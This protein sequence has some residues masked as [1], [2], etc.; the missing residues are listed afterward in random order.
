MNISR[1]LRSCLR[2]FRLIEPASYCKVRHDWRHYTNRASGTEA[3]T[4][5]DRS[6]DIKSRKRRLVG[7]NIDGLNATEHKWL[8]TAYSISDEMDVENAVKLLVDRMGHKVHAL[9]DDVHEEGVM[10]R[11]ASDFDVSPQRPLHDIFLF[12]EGAIVFWGVPFDKQQDTLDTIRVA[13]KSSYSN[14]LTQ[15]E[16]ESLDYKIDTTIAKSK[17]SRNRVHLSSSRNESNFCMDQFA[18][19][20]AVALSV[21]LGVWESMLDKYIDSVGWVTDKMKEGNYEILSRDQIFRKIGELFD[22]KHNINLATDLTDLPDVYWDREEQE[23]MFSATINF[24][25]IRKR[26][27]VMNDKLNNCCELMNLLAAHTNDRH[28]VR[29]EYLI[30]TLIAIEV[31]FELGKLL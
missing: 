16:V 3:T 9:P 25:N 12:K 7:R 27:A 20:H 13:T 14:V 23:D 28:H 11:G 2:S 15:S 6:I 26:T 17:L 30:I 19:S 22:L 8:V 31:G 1:S 24:L 18:F 29:L 5:S 10:L 4:Q 21:K